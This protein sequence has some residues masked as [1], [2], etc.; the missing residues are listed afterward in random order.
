[1][2]FLTSGKNSQG[3]FSKWQ[4][5]KY[6]ISQAAFFQVCPN[7]RVR[8]FSPSCHSTQPHCSLRCL[9]WPKEPVK[10]FVGMFRKMKISLNDNWRTAVWFWWSILTYDPVAPGPNSSPKHPLV[11]HCTPRTLQYPQYQPMPPPS[12]PQYH[13]VPGGTQQYHAVPHSTLFWSPAPP[14]TPSIT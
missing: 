13:P 12:A 5:P 7:C 11:P 10:S 9:R 4:L 6:V 14:S 1:M 8:L 3:Y 2:I